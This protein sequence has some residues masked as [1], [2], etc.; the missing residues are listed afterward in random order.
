[1]KQQ[2]TR[3]FLG[4]RT[5]RRFAADTA[6]DT[7]SEH[8]SKIDPRVSS[9]TESKTARDRDPRTFETQ[10][11]VRYKA[12]IVTTANDPEKTVNDDHGRDTAKRERPP[13]RW[14]G[15]R[16]PAGRQRHQEEE[17][18]EEA[19]PEGRIQPTRSCSFS[20]PN[21]WRLTEFAKSLLLGARRKRDLTVAVETGS[22]EKVD[23]NGEFCP[24]RNYQRV[25]PDQDP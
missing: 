21:C 10:T 5:V 12:Q 11:Q 1:M 14:S 4:K 9:N 20:Q 8:R 23:P 22:E 6:R 19:S 2:V 25:S 7:S 3:R 15:R 18:D 13:R 24:T 16:D 17:S